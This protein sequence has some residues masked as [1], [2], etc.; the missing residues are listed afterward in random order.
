[1][2]EMVTLRRDPREPCHVAAVQVASRGRSGIRGNSHTLAVP[3]L[4][5]PIDKRLNQWT[6]HCFVA[7]LSDSLPKLYTDIYQVQSSCAQAKARN[8]RSTK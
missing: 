6:S 4:Q 5:Y 2:N 8:K 7:L 1:M 3:G